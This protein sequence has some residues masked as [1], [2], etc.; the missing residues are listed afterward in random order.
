M[1]QKV[2]PPI[3]LHR[4]YSRHRV[5]NSIIL[6][7]SFQL[8]TLFFPTSNYNHWRFIVVSYEQKS[9][10]VEVTNIFFTAAMITFFPKTMLTQSIFQQPE[11]IK[12]GRCQIQMMWR[13]W[14]DSS[15]KIYNM[16]YELESKWHWIE[17]SNMQIPKKKKKKKKKKN[18]AISR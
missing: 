4:N 8:K 15:A 18:A 12:V 17:K 13:F 9:A 2:M 1:L 5:C 11:Q 16:I 6:L 14:E 10:P 7:D 3:C